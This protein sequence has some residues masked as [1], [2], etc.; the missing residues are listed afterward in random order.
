MIKK[1]ILI[2]VLVASCKSQNVPLKNSK[3]KDVWSILFA[4][5]FKEDHVDLFLNGQEV[6]KN[7]YLYSDES[8][9]VTTLWIRII[10]EKGGFYISNFQEKTLKPMNL[11]IDEIELNLIYKGVNKKNKFKKNDGKFLIIRDNGKGELIISQSKKQ[12]LFY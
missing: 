3:D 1:L 8:D 4:D 12:L 2:L 9:G 5:G 11:K 10:K 6:I 7:G